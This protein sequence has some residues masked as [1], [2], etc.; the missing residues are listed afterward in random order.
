[1]VFITLD[2][3]LTFMTYYRACSKK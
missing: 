2:E 3:F 1:V